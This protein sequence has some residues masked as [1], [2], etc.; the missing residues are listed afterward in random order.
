MHN[1]KKQHNETG[2]VVRPRPICSWERCNESSMDF[3]HQAR[4][5]RDGSARNTKSS[6]TKTEHRVCNL[7]CTPQKDFIPRSVADNPS[8]HSFLGRAFPVYDRVLTSAD[9]VDTRLLRAPIMGTMG[10]VA[11]FVEKLNG[12]STITATAVFTVQVNAPPTVAGMLSLSVEWGNDLGPGCD[13]FDEDVPIAYTQRRRVFIDFQDRLACL[14]VPYVSVRNSYNLNLPFTSTTERGEVGTVSLYLLSPPAGATPLPPVH[15]TVLYHLEDIVLGV[16]TDNTVTR[17][18]ALYMWEEQAWQFQA[19]PGKYQPWAQGQ[20]Q[21]KHATSK[22]AEAPSNVEYQFGDNET[23]PQ[24]D[25]VVLP[26]Q[27]EQ[28]QLDEAVLPAGEPVVEK[29]V[30]HF[31]FSTLLNKVANVAGFIGSKIPAIAEYAAIGSVAA[32]SAAYLLEH[33]GWSRPEDHTSQ[34]IMIDTP[35]RYNYTGNGIDSS[36]VLGMDTDNHVG[37]LF[38]AEPGCS[39]PMA[40]ATIAAIPCVVQRFLLNTSDAVGSRPF[41]CSVAPVSG[42][43]FGSLMQEE[44]VSS[45]GICRRLSP[46]GQVASYFEYWHGTMCYKLTAVGTKFHQGRLMISHRPFAPTGTPGYLNAMSKTNKI[47]WDLS[48]TKTM[49][50]KVGMYANMHW[51]RSWAAFPQVAETDWMNGTLGVFVINPLTGPSNVATTIEVLIEMWMEDAKFA[52]PN[53]KVLGFT[54]FDQLPPALPEGKPSPEEGKLPPPE[55]PPDDDWQYQ[56][57]VWQAGETAVGFIGDEGAR[58]HEYIYDVTM[59]EKI[60]SLKNLLQVPHT[61]ANTTGATVNSL[62]FHANVPVVPSATDWGGTTDGTANS[63]TYDAIMMSYAWM[64]GSVRYQCVNLDNDGTT[65][66]AW[67]GTTTNDYTNVNWRVGSSN[68]VWQRATHSAGQALFIRTPQYVAS[69]AQRILPAAF[70]AAGTFAYAAALPSFSLTQR[71]ILVGQTFQV[72]RL[73]GDDLHLQGWRGAN[74]LLVKSPLYVNDA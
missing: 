20:Q 11:A 62:Q 12:I 46:C 51:L 67:Q 18:D 13:I 45:F 5:T 54:R 14:R 63:S 60:L 43:S 57:G 23:Q 42:P 48:E 8:I 52:A 59:G 7:V 38:N 72:K 36:A 50:F 29:E 71:T 49:M 37:S 24:S 32:S 25:A 9:S 3:E 68:D 17:T 35:F 22:D 74:W 6:D 15:V 41:V 31:R 40:L 30:S 58:D 55:T 4:N 33:F 61:L 10:K 27:E 64:T 28:T 47:M 34:M 66:W 56:A 70:A 73:A 21:V 26:N 65:M 2:I 19:G 16:P 39:D 53:H 44:Y 1:I 69:H